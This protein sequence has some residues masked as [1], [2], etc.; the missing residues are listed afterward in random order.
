MHT[1]ISRLFGF[2]PDNPR[3]PVPEETF[4]THTHRGHQ[5]PLSASSIY[6]DPDVLIT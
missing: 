3:E 5:S 1:T 6:Y 4:T 2:C